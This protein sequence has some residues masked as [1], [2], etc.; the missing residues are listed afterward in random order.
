MGY[1]DTPI[2][3]REAREY[4]AMDR[5]LHCADCGERLTMN[6]LMATLPDE[7]GDR[8]CI[9]CTAYSRWLKER[10]EA[11]LLPDAERAEWVRVH[12]MP[13]AGVAR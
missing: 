12:P 11:E 4:R 1:F 9:A 6:D 3:E 2:S 5:K 8:F 13:Y 10:I 7:D